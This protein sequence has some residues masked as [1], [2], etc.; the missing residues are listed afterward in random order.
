MMQRDPKNTQLTHLG[1]RDAISQ[2][3]FLCEIAMPQLTNLSSN[4]PVFRKLVEPLQ[5]CLIKNPHARA[6]QT[7]SDSEWLETGVLR[8]LSEVVSGRHFLQ[9]LFYLGKVICVGTFFATL[10]SSRRLSHLRDTLSSL[11]D[12]MLEKRQDA[13][14]LREFDELNSFQVFATD[15]HYHAHACHDPKIGGKHRSAQHFYCLN[16][17]SLGL[18]HFALAEIGNDVKKESD[19]KACKKKNAEEMR[20]GA[21]KGIRTLYVWDRAIIDYKFWVEMKKKAVYFLTLCK[22]NLRFE[23]EKDLE[24]NSD[25]AVN[26]GVLCDQMV[27]S[28][29][30]GISVRRVSY[31]CPA[32]G[33]V[34]NFL[35]NLH[36]SVRPGVVALLYKMRWDIEKVFDEIKNRLGEKKSWSTNPNGKMAQAY[37]ICLAHNLLRL[38]EDQLEAEGATNE[39]D[40]ERRRLRLEEALERRHFKLNDAPNLLKLTNR[41][42]QR[43][44]I[45]IRW[46]RPHLQL[47][48]LWSDAVL[49]L[50]ASYVEFSR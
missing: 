44:T 7:T 13:D 4:S 41:L 20:Q 38:L 26:Q 33:K 28:K 21:G 10:R 22:S 49:S 35:T 39:Q 45:L 29:T 37:F 3:T 47:P 43:S 27:R 14:P 16:Y 24:F 23:L 15:G 6:C 9:K 46:L 5:Q 48:V 30:D 18:S 25:D 8:V 12:L 42:V 34:F 31:R 1:A 50:R 17:R 19:L 36:H 2:F 40:P 32:S 11:L